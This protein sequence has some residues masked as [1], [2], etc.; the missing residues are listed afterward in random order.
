LKNN[1]YLCKEGLSRKKRQKKDS[2]LKNEV[3]GTRK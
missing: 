3:S 2:R 1:K